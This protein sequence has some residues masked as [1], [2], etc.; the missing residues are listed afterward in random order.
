LAIESSF[1]F[2]T[3]IIAVALPTAITFRKAFSRIYVG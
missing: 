3:A 2:N 1:L